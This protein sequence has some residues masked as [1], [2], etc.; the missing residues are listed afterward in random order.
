MF[1]LT[2]NGVL[3]ASIIY[4]L[5]QEVTNALLWPYATPP[6][7]LLSP[8]GYLPR[9]CN[10]SVITKTSYDGCS[11]D[12]SPCCADARC[13]ESPEMQTLFTL[14]IREHNAYVTKLGMKGAG[15]EPHVFN[16]A[17]NHIIEILASTCVGCRGPTTTCSSD[18][19]DDLLKLLQYSVPREDVFNDS[20]ACD[21]AGVIIC[22]AN[23][24]GD[25]EVPLVKILPPT[26][27]TLTDPLNFTYYLEVTNTASVLSL[28]SNVLAFFESYYGVDGNATALIVF[29]LSERH[30]PGEED[31]VGRLGHALLEACFGVSEPVWINSAAARKIISDFY[32]STCPVECTLDSTILGALGTSGDSASSSTSSADHNVQNG[33]LIFFVVMIGILTVAFFVLVMYKLFA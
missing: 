27:A 20:D 25:F 9:F 19:S 28:D 11:L 15:H 29:L 16:L 1:D 32:E 31:I 22:D 18:V 14:L 21:S 8:S 26:N 5:T 13:G 24:T 30:G 17:R 10:E 4:G 12:D 6:Y 7:M 33:S 2:D 3:D 23:I